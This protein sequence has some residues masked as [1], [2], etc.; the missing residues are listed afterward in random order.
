MS[1]RG[2]ARLI[3]T[4]R[5]AAAHRLANHRGGGNSPN[6]THRPGGKAGEDEEPNPAGRSVSS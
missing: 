3:A 1:R 5:V 6:L 4:R 2:F